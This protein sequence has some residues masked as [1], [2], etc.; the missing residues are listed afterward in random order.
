MVAASEP[1]IR[2]SY[3]KTV[4]GSMKQCSP[5]ERVALLSRLDT[6]LRASIRE[7]SLLDWISAQDFA[8]LV[9]LVL[10]V[11]GPARARAFW[12]ANLLRSLDRTLL[13]PL[14]LGAVALYGESP[15]S[16]IRMA[17]Q[18]WQLVS[19][20]GGHCSTSDQPPDAFTLQFSRLPPELRTPGLLQ[21]WAGGSEACIELLKFTGSAEAELDP[22]DAN[23]VVV[24][25]RWQPR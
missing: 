11:L 24:H 7:A 19:R 23:G 1:A 25:V 9:N 4:V 6:T 16:L 17:P 20:H 13:S 10:E 8:K 3:A 2:A 15:G 12:R 18:A 14:R 22:A 21:L 5:T